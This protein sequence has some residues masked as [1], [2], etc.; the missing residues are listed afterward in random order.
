MRSYSK[1]KKRNTLQ[2]STL[3][4]ETGIRTR[5]TLSSKHAF[6]A[7]ALSHSATSPFPRCGVQKYLKHRLET[8]T[9]EHT[10]N[11]D[12]TSSL[13]VRR[14]TFNEK[15][16]AGQLKELKWVNSPLRLLNM[17]WRISCPF[18]PLP[19]E[20]M[21]LVRAASVVISPPEMTPQSRNK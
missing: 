5:V 1:K 8:K 2:Y 16:H 12:P 19:K 11:F 20:T 18:H 10:K 9:M 15:A 13:H 4:G 7:C 6:Q 17:A 14:E 21:S 3:C